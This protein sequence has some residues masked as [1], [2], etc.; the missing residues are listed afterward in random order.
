MLTAAIDLLMKKLENLG[1]N[2][3]KMVDARVTC[4]ECG[5]IGH[6][7]IN[8]L[9]VPHDVNFVGNSNNSFVLIKASMLG[10]TN[11]VSYSITANKVVMGRIS[12]EMSPLSEISLGIR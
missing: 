1:L 9:T 2:H 11:P 4:E 6:M 5:E 10:G 8:C 3:L 12:T 7:G